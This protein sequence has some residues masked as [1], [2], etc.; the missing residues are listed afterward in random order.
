[1]EGVSGQSIPLWNSAW[2]PDADCPSLTSSL[3]VGS[4]DW[5]VANFIYEGGQVLG[6]IKNYKLEQ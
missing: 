4:E 6:F 1:M 5:K 2:L 3:M